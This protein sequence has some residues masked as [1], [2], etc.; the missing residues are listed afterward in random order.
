[1]DNATPTTTRPHFAGLNTAFLAEVLVGHP[2]LISYADI[3]RRPGVWTKEILPRLERGDYVA[4]ILDSGAFTELTTPGFTVSVEAYATF[5]ADFGHLFD[6]VVTLDDIRGDLARTWK[7]TAELMKTGA[8]I[9]PVFHGREPFEV[10][11]MYCRKFGRVGLGFARDRGRISKDQGHGMNPA[12]WLEKALDI[13]EAAGV[14]IHGFGMTRYALSLGHGRLTTTDSTTWIAE[15]CALQ[16]TKGD[17]G[18]KGAAQALI[19][20]MPRS[21]VA[22][23]TIA[24]YAGAGACQAMDQLLADSWGQARTVFRRMSAA[25]LEA[26]GN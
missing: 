19:D 26:F 17:H 18:V 2:V 8:E 25:D 9:I 20:A 16:K 4:P 23:F 14:E 22:L 5:I 24:S 7:N 21:A 13:C 15:F 1:M 12:A 6:Q 10:L 3:I 11:E